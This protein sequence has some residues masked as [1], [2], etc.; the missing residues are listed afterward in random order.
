[1]R[2]FRNDE[3]LAIIQTEGG[4]VSEREAAES[5]LREQLREQGIHQASFTFDGFEKTAD[6]NDIMAKA[7]RLVQSGN[8]NILRNGYNAVVGDV[9]GDHGRYQT[10]ISRDDPQSRAITQWTCECPWD[11]YAFQRTRQWKKY[12][13]RPCAHVLATYWQSLATPLDEEIHPGQDG[14]GQLPIPGDGGYQWQ[15]PL[16]PKPP[17]AP[18]GPKGPRAPLPPHLQPPR[19]PAELRM[20]PEGLEQ[21]QQLQLPQMIPGTGQGQPPQPAPPG[22][23]IP[24]AQPAG[25]GILPPY[26]QVQP[27]QA[28]AVSVPGARPPTPADPVA[29]P[30]GTFSRYNANDGTRRQTNSFEGS[31]VEAYPDPGR[32]LDLDGEQDQGWLWEGTL[33]ASAMASSS[34][35]LYGDGRRDTR[36][37]GS[38]PR[39]SGAELRQSGAH[40]TSFAQD[41]RLTWDWAYGDQLTQD[42]MR[43]GASSRQERGGAA[44]LSDLRQGVYALED[45]KASSQMES[46]A[47]GALSKT[48]DWEDFDF[49]PEQEDFINPAG[50]YKW[51][52]DLERHQL[53][54]GPSMESHYGIALD[55]GMQTGDHTVC[56]VMTPEGLVHEFSQ[57]FY[58]PWIREALTRYNPRA[59]FPETRADLEQAHQY[60]FHVAG[61]NDSFENAQIARLE[62]D[63][64]GQAVG[65]S[66]QHG[67]GSWREVPKNS[68][69]EIM[70][71]DPTT[72]WVEINFP[73]RDSG[74]ME[75][76]HVQCF[77]EP[78]K[79]TPMPGIAPPGPFIKRRV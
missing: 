77:V 67:A 8:V 26:P 63:T 50:G 16:P 55:N 70:G 7:K 33:P 20:G 44:P 38:R 75:P 43:E 69:G 58:E 51:V 5:I 3:G 32:A 47:R 15:G 72:G 13:G 45:A 9:E 62:E 53:V 59:R 52:A 12:E 1:M 25:P 6:W 61:K 24:G 46:G 28:P 17:R 37:D 68:I 48:A 21:P 36:G 18:L 14:Q 19:Q 4:S 65:K 23:P 11:Q 22:Q 74:P 30:G 27:L 56:G 49:E 71:Q 79:L 73:I 40:G 57:R 34:S 42:Y 64:Y 31:N 76:F 35:D 54:V 2:W 29:Y 66:E 10:E 39:L 78:D 41:E 60:M